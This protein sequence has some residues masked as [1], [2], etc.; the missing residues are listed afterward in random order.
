MTPE[1]WPHWSIG[2][3][4]VRV[5][6]SITVRAHISWWQL[7]SFNWVSMD[8][9]ATLGRSFHVRNAPHIVLLFVCLF[10]YA[11]WG[12]GRTELIETNNHSVFVN[13]EPCSRGA[14]IY[15]LVLELSHLPHVR[16][17][18]TCSLMIR[19][20]YQRS[21]FIYTR[22]YQVAFPRGLLE[23]GR[24]RWWWDILIPLCAVFH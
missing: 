7:P 13:A 9:S 8:T 23:S 1:A 6:S 21:Y 18:Q 24:G 16:V 3:I 10:I 17:C 19:L 11:F 2:N 15:S 5:H 12:L 14:V 20:H 4:A 22:L